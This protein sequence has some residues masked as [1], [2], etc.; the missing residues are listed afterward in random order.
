MEKEKAKIAVNFN[1]VKYVNKAC[2]LPLLGIKNGELLILCLVI[3][4]VTFCQHIK[5]K[6]VK[7]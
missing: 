4:S 5:S 1:H 3:E 2:L 6:R 7:S